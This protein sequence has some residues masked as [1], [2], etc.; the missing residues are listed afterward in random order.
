MR[1]SK[2]QNRKQLQRLFSKK[3]KKG[4]TIV[5][6]TLAT[7]FVAVLMIS[8][9]LIT[10][11]I[12]AI[13]QKGLTLRAVSSVGRGLISELTTSINAAPSVDVVSLCNMYLTDPDATNRCI[14]DGAFKF[15]Y[16]ESVANTIDTVSH[17]GGNIQYGGVFC[18]GT[19]SYIWNTYYARNQAG[20][21]LGISL[22]YRSAH[23][24]LAQGTV[25]P[26]GDISLIRFEDKTYRACSSNVNPTTY[27]FID[28]SPVGPNFIRPNHEVDMRTLA[29]G[30]EL[31]MPVPQSNFL[32]DSEIPLDLYELVIFPISIDSVTYRAFFS[33][34][35]ILATT[36]GDVSVLRTGDYCDPNGMLTGNTA[37]ST[38]DIGS[39]FNY[40][41]INKFNF[42]ARTAGSGI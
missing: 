15:L 16:Q 1:K 28:R 29:N 2:T 23:T 18:S 32:D 40:C 24:D 20:L 25:L 37:T 9:T 6:V 36:N 17:S 4:F 39:Q 3:T 19:Y 34:T 5:E 11:S 27:E 7:A 22:R 41:G 31:L 14:K 30:V 12:A 35:F 21:G 33:G 8:I 38:L 13:F 42:A 26:G 10:T